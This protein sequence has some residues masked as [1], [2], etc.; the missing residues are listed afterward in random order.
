MA[1]EIKILTSSDYDD[2]IKVWAISGLP[3]KPKGR[4][5]YE[6]LTKEMMNPECAFF[7]LYDDNNM[8]GV[9]IA[10]FDGRRGWINRL[11]I[12]PDYRGQKH[13]GRLIDK[14]EEFLKERGALVICALIGDINYPSI[15]TFQTAGYVCEN[16]IKYFA[17][18]PSYDI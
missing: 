10:N 12:D 14:A 18:R 17:K 11:A 16:E 6:L 5:S 4:D 7:G 13:A 2:I 9:V 1:L 8:I 3:Y 15:S